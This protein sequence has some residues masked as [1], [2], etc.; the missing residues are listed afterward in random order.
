[1][2]SSRRKI[3]HKAVWPASHHT[4]NE[5]AKTRRWAIK[6]SFPG[7]SAVKLRIAVVCRFSGILGQGGTLLTVAAAE[8]KKNG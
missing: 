7:V 1:M 6:L 4:A 5:G 2:E 8:E 3:S